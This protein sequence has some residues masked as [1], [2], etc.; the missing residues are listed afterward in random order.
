MY[1]LHIKDE[2]TLKLIVQVT[3]WGACRFHPSCTFCC[4]FS[5]FTSGQACSSQLT[6]EPN[7]DVYFP[8]RHSVLMDAIWHF[9]VDLMLLRCPVQ[10]GAYHI[11]NTLPSESEI[12]WPMS[13][14]YCLGVVWIHYLSFDGHS[15]NGS[16]WCICWTIT[17]FKITSKWSENRL[18]SVKMQLDQFKLW[19]GL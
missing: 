6:A 7:S 10:T 2:C 8:D 13:R 17:K 1:L 11:V 19:L 14:D 12:T 5:L 18:I 16:A 9:F 15:L 3:L 4:V